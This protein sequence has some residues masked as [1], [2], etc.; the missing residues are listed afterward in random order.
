V[1]EEGTRLIAEIARKLG[2]TV[3]SIQTEPDLR[4]QVLRR[5]SESVV[6]DLIRERVTQ[7][8]T[9]K[10][11]IRGIRVDPPEEI[12]A[13]KLCALLSR[14]EIR[15]L[16]DVRALEIAGYRVEDALQAAALKDTG[17]TP[18]QLSWVLSQMK[19]GDDLVPP[20]DV[21]V[22]EL[23]A[24]LADLIARLTRLAAPNSQSN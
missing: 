10:P 14:S 5:G 11:V 22:K 16:V 19:L 4:R 9:Q 7:L 1:L 23:R 8:I 20:G 12:L 15:D 21:T 17:L 2:A 24:Y 3:E 13:N 6:I 18:A